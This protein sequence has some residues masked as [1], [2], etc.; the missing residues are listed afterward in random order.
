MEL[1]EK[2]AL[3]EN[4]AQEP[5]RITISTAGGSTA[6]ASGKEFGT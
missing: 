4:A 3:M 6:P 2:R 1:R 5:F